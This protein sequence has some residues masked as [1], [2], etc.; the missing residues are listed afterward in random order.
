MCAWILLGVV[1]VQNGW[2]V[3]DQS[4]FL[5]FVLVLVLVFF[6]FGWG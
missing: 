3:E 2:S 1:Q 6:S 4:V 5:V